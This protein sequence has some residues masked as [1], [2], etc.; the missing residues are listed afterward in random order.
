MIENIP[1]ELVR[2]GIKFKIHLYISKLS[3]SAF[4]LGL[5]FDVSY[6]YGTMMHMA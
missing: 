1:R 4:M 6:S 5:S 2:S 3:T